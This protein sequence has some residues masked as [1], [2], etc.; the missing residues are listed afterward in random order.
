M[1]LQEAASLVRALSKRQ[2]KKKKKEEETFLS[3]AIKYSTNLKD[4]NVTTPQ[5]QYLLLR[6]LE[7]KT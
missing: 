4:K 5:Y 2:K 6:T 1:K 3:I 7:S